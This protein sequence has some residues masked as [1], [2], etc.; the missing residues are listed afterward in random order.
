[1]KKFA[2]LSVL[3]LAF[4]AT[5]FAAVTFDPTCTLTPSNSQ[6]ACGFV[7]K[8]DLQTPWVWTNQKIQVEAAA[9]NLSFDYVNIG[10]FEFTCEWVTGNPDS[11]KGTKTHDITKTKHTGISGAVA[12][13]NRSNKQV[14]GILL[15]GSSFTS[16]GSIDP[17]KVGDSCLGEGAD[18]VITVVTTISSSNE[19]DASDTSAGTGP[20]KIWPPPPIL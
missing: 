20:T 12:Y 14:D 7:G 2:T 13:S 17:P 16:T 15:T 6:G 8:G 11:P 10:V 1:M 3:L 5:S 9:G 4:A 18:G 19:L